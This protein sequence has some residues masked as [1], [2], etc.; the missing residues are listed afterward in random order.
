MYFVVAYKKKFQ[1]ELN[2]EEI[3]EII[4]DMNWQGT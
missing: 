1:P 4:K 2:L 3:L